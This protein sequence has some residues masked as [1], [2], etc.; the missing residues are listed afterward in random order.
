MAT[1][2]T[3]KKGETSTT[4]SVGIRIDP[5]IKFALDMMGRE[6]KRSLTA[7][8]EWAISNA[9]A[10]QQWSFD[11][12]F[13]DVI[14]RVWSTDEATRFVNMAFFMPKS[15]TYDELRVWETIKASQ[16]FWVDFSKPGTYENLAVWMVRDN[17]HSLLGHIERHKTSASVVPMLDTEAGVTGFI[18]DVSGEVNQKNASQSSFL[19]LKAEDGQYTFRLIAGN[20]QILLNGG[21]YKTKNDALA[22]IEAVR[23]SSKKFESFEISNSG[24]RH[25]V[26]LTSSNGEVLGRGV[27]YSGAE[28]IGAWIS[29]I[30]GLASKAEIK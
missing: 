27:N 8:V 24:N 10:Q 2:P 15:L 13:A 18:K 21:R 20:S 29:Q 12:T 19:L 22:A 9:I 25:Q 5:K 1:K 23:L 3:K 14:D 11:E 4:V 6:Q 17:W 26:V 7:V 28:E 30:A 16:V